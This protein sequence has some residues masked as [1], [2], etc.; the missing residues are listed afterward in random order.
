[1]SENLENGRDMIAEIE[2]PVALGHMGQSWLGFYLALV[3]I[4][5]ACAPLTEASASPLAG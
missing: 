3:L 4:F 5:V 2:S 1:M